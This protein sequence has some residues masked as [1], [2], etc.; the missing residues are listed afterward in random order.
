W[1]ETGTSFD[2][3]LKP[4][5]YQTFWFYA[6]LGLGCFGLGLALYRLR[7]RQV[8]GQFSAVLAERNRLAGEIHDTLAQGF[9]GIALQLQAV[10]KMIQVAPQTAH[11]HLELA[12]KMVNHSLAEARRSI[13]NLRSQ[14]LEGG[15]LGAAL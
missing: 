9:V 3:Y 14:A 12:Q 5:F 11:Q 8:K 4:H 7:I 13:W 15:D 2:F 1:S 10:G 6:S